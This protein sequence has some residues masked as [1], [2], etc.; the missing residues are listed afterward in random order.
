MLI[1]VIDYSAEYDIK[2]GLWL[3]ELYLYGRITDNEFVTH[4]MLIK[5]KFH[6]VLYRVGPIPICHITGA[7]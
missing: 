4:T 6:L 5:F 3:V 1:T 7:I 2:V